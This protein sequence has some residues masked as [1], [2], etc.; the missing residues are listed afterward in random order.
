MDSSNECPIGFYCP[1][2]TGVSTSFPCDVGKYG[3]SAGLTSS[4]EC[5]DCPEKFYC[6]KT[7]M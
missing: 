6:P 1:S 4:E 2:G 5:D 3:P 7:G